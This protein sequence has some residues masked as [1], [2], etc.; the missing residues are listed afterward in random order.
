MVE[1]LTVSAVLNLYLIW[2]FALLYRRLQMTMA[3]LYK[4]SKGQM[5]ISY[6]EDGVEIKVKK[7]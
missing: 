3:I 6:D 2:R 1:L 4:V 7:S 5:S